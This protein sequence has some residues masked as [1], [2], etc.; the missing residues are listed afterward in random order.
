MLKLQLQASE[1]AVDEL[2]ARQ[3]KLLREKKF[4][5]D[6]LQEVPAS[7]R[8]GASMP[9]GSFRLFPFVARRA[10]AGV[11]GTSG[12]DSKPVLAELQ[13]LQREYS[14]LND[15]FRAAQEQLRADD[16]ADGRATRSSSRK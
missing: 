7:E 2:E 10:Q 14:E 16:G 12:I 4:L 13:T 5:A 3:R 11:T 8:K 15:R 1:A 6:E 9:L